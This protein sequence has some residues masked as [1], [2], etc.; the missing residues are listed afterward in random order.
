M[1]TGRFDTGPLSFARTFNP[2]GAGRPPDPGGRVARRLTYRQRIDELTFEHE[3]IADLA[4][5]TQ[6]IMQ[7][8]VVDVPQIA[9]EPDP[10]APE[11][12]ADA[13]GARLRG[14]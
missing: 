2:Q 10:P 9:P 3:H 6:G 13:I 14:R 5:M 1:T 7:R 8:C 4:A 11:M 12:R